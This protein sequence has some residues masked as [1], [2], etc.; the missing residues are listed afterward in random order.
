MTAEQATQLAE[1]GRLAFNRGDYFEAHEHWEEVWHEA[2]GDDR[3]MLQGLIQIAAGL[4]KLKQGRDD[5]CVKLIDK[6]L[7][8][9]GTEGTTCFGLGVAAIREEVARLREAV[10][11]GLPTWRP[12]LLT[13]ATPRTGR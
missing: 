4:Y 1:E 8:K 11:Q 13:P 9:L 5:L 7:D 2:A 10:E 3:R 12:L 6:G